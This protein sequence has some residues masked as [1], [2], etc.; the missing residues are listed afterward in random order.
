MVVDGDEGA[1][2]A[3]DDKEVRGLPADFVSAFF[4][5]QIF[6]APELVDEVTADFTLEAESIEML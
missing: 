4:E 6:V 1:V 3:F 5:P 2:A